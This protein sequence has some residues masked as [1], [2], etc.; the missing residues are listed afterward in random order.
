MGRI[1]PWQKYTSQRSG[2]DTKRIQA[3]KD[4]AFLVDPAEYDEPPPS[5]RSLG[6]E[7]DVSQGEMRDD[8]DFTIADTATPP[9]YDNPIVYIT[10]AGG[11]TPN[12]HPFMLISGSNVP[13]TISANPQIVR[14][15][16]NQVLTLWCADS[17]V[18]I[19]NG[20]GIATMG[21]AP[22]NMTSGAVITFIYNTGGNVWQ[23]TSR[24]R[25]L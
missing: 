8:S 10:A 11:I 4:G 6:G 7:G 25:N 16:Q 14:G 19:S 20:N 18:T 1:S 12:T 13:V 9:G 21:S 5:R 17:T 3:I 23:E 22:F 24:S 2:F 15:K